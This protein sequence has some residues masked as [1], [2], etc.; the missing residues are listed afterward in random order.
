MSY[1]AFENCCSSSLTSCKNLRSEELGSKMTFAGA[2]GDMSMGLC[3]SLHE[4]H[5][6]E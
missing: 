6:R 4:E 5:F 3:G 1:K 2:V